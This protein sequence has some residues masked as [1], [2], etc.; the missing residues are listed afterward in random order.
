MT[1][2]NIAR[3]V[4]TMYEK[5]PLELKQ[6]P[7]WVG[8]KYM[9]RPG[10][11]HKRKVPINAMDG[12]PA[13]SN[14]P[15]TWCDFD[16]ACLGKERFGLDGIGFMFSGDGIFG[17]D[18]DHCYDPETQELDPAAAEIIETVQS[19]TELSPSGTGIHILC[20]GVLPEGRKRRGAV[21]MYSTL[22]Y[23]TVT[24]N[25]FGLEY[26]FS[27]C[28]ERVAVM[29]RKY[30]GEE[31]TAAGAQKAALP[32]P[33]G[34][35][36]NADMSVDAI[37]R[38]MFDSKHGQ[39]LQDLYNGS[40]ER[41]GIGDGSQSSADQ[42]FCNTLAFWCRCDAALMDAIFRR[43][44]L[45][46]QKWDK[47]R[48]AKTYG[49]ITIDRAIKDCRDIWEP[50]ERVQRPAPAVPLPPQ[51]TSNEVPAIENATVGETGQR[52]YY[53]YDD[54]GNALRFRDANAGL[55]HYNH[56]DGCWIYWDGV[57][58][59]SDENGEIKRRADKMLAD[60]AKDLKEMQDDPAYNAYKKHLSRSRSHR[61]KEGFIAEAR[62]LEGV[63]V[64]PS[65][66]DRAGN[67]FNVRNCLISL[68]TGR[69]A[70]HDKKYMISKLAPVTYDENAKC[71]RW[72]R[73]IE[74]ITCGDKSL[75]LYL[76]R[77]IGY[78]MT[79]Y[80]KEQCMFFLYGN[81]SNGKSVF[82]DTIA[83][84]L[85][86]YA[87]SCQPETVMMRDRNNTARGDLARLKGARMVVTSEPNDGCRLD[88]GI[89]K[90]MTG[91]TENKLTARFLYGR[92]FEFSPEFK[93]VMSTNYKPVIKGTDN[94][95]WRRVRLIPF[96]A[97]FTKEN[98]DPQ[99]TEKLRRELPGILNWAI[100]GAVGW[101]KEG[102]PPCA[103]IDEAGQEYRS[104]MD[105]VQQF[106]D[107]CTTRSE[108]SSTQASTLYK[109]YKAWCSE[110]GDRF[111][112]GSTK[113]FME[114]KRRFKSRKTEAYNE[115]IGIKIN[116]L[117]MDLYTRAER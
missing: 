30:L 56:V 91:G 108:S 67:A 28:T 102:L 83:Y 23:F 109:C 117:G 2:R 58:W 14:D 42:A 113:F 81:G 76:Q 104:E 115:Y 6:L 43:S 106:L 27:D 12:Q 31:E 51:N 19:Y 21:E 114:L 111:P 13:K 5:I 98:R 50:Q 63:P 103:I 35:G 70:E 26:P 52:R 112:V 38:R 20:K 1:R 8:W 87:A 47:R 110:Q 116:D 73:F 32:M 33:T 3:K 55:I 44:G 80:T 101:C 66:M 84:M 49:Q 69:T 65:E 100:A 36:T 78:C 64:L 99:L 95:I 54:T 17:I 16:T 4:N 71:P 18:I 24:G 89:V 105:R 94:G 90:Q 97:E 37:L 82:V 75:Q 45:Y 34:R 57:R 22:R 41:Y 72:D 40:W 68:K 59:A 7:H 15:T 85:G 39:K 107:D 60:M 92:E 74:E 62:H 53:T 77:M 29:H 88:E 25:Q 11:D 86:E 96:T 48:G 79:A 9:Q 10:E 93:I 61:G 46:R